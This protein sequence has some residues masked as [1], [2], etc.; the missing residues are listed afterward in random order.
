[1]I[2]TI[3]KEIKNENSTNNKQKLLK[4]YNNELFK[5]VLF[6]TY[7][8]FYTFNVKKFNKDNNHSCECSLEDSFQVLDKLRKREITGHA[9]IKLVE[10]MYKCLCKENAEV[11]DKI[12]QKDLK[13]GVNVKLINKVFE[14]LI[15]ISPYLGAIPYDDK[16]FK[17]LLEKAPLI[18]Q[19]K[20]DGMFINLIKN[21]NQILTISRSGKDLHLS[22]AFDL[23]ELDEGVVITGELMVNGF[24]RYSSNGVLNS[25]K[26]IMTK[27]DEG[28]LSFKDEEKFY[29]SYRK[30]PKE[31]IEDI[32]IVA[33]DYIPYEKWSKGKDETPYMERFNKLKESNKIKIVE[34]RFISTFEE[35][36][37]HFIEVKNKGGEGTIVKDKNVIFQ[38]KKPNDIIKFKIIVELDMKIVGYLYGNKETKYE[39][40][41]NRLVC[42]TSD[43]IIKTTTSGVDE[44]TMDLFTEMKDNL[45]GKIA[46]VECSGLS[47]V[48]GKVEALLHPRFV[49]L[50]EDKNEAD[51]LNT[52][53]KIEEAAKELKCS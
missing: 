36:M 20:M 30:T 53:I 48:D 8:P 23:N 17:K 46:S 18:S 34:T 50:R 3:I 38:N 13:M 37:N 6:Y 47:W 44:K 11:F 21:D 51:D 10:D 26:T 45:I 43:G 25:L 16:K 2:Y 41:I 19:E 35:A 1:M 29:K 42:E 33:W 27:K 4:K 49:S 32:Y 14:N 28:K 5:K 31:I 40:K 9:A 7:N 15:P 39:N 22:D 52:A 12:L 24:D